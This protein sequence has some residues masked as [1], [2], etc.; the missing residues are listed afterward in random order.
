MI[1]SEL[2]HYTKM[3]IALEKILYEKRIKIGQLG[4][5]NDPK[6]SEW[7]PVGVSY[8]EGFDPKIYHPSL[9][10]F[11]QVVAE[12][13]RVAKEEWKA[14]C[15]TKHIP[16]RN[17]KDPLKRD[18]YSRFRKG[19][20]RPRMWAQYCENH[21]GICIVFDGKKLLSKISTALQDSI[22][23]HGP[24]IYKDYKA[25][26]HEC[27]EYKDIMSLGLT[28]GVRKYYLTHYSNFFLTKYPDW[29][30]ESEYRILVHN[31]TA[32]FELVNIEGTIKFVLVGS[33][34]LKAYEPSLIVLCKEWNIPAGRMQW[35]NGLP[36]AVLNDIYN[37]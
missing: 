10:I 25:I 20:N 19:Y 37:P 9:S 30:N 21:T 26:A 17:F 28:D 32:N 3:N 12:S 29:E 16:N 24:I 6:E 1:P 2:C 5:T 27:I 13:S 7:T 8:P 15:L 36:T 18:I 23:F 33:K 11:G 14:L 35:S 34:F 22:I 4:S 31:K